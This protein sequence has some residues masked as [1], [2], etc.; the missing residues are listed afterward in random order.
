MTIRKY[1]FE[2]SFDEGKSQDTNV[3]V[4]RDGL[5]EEQRE[6]SLQDK[7]Q[8]GFQEGFQ[9]GIESQ[10]NKRENDVLQVLSHIETKVKDLVSVYEA[11][12]S[13]VLKLSVFF[14]K[15]ILKKAFP[16][17]SA[18]QTLVASDLEEK[19]LPVIKKLAGDK[20]KVFV[21][22]SMAGFI[23]SRLRSLAGVNVEVNI[24]EEL[25][26]GDCRLCWN[27]S[28]FECLQERLGREVYALLDDM[29]TVQ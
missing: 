9:K 4:V 7:F 26:P 2:R 27:E 8:E 5:V 29:A 16:H 3:P 18:N 19:I 11:Q 24:D 28:G 20:V 22:K 13:E 6:K 25:G 1:I 12:N 17:L 23:E 21:H 10:A 14:V 15:S